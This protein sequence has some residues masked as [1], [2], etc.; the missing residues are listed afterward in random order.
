MV[1]IF[2]MPHSCRLLKPIFIF[3]MGSLLWAVPLWRN[4]LVFHDVDKV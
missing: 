3:V 4:S 1:A 2:V